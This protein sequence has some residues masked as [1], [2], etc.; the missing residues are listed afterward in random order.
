[1]KKDLIS[2]LLTKLRNAS[3]VFHKFVDIEYSKVNE[4]I[5][6]L[7]KKEGYIQNYETKSF[8]KIIVELRFNGWWTKSSF[9]SK[10]IRIS[11][12][13]R[14]IYSSYKDFNKK[15]KGLNFEQGII[16]L[17]TSSGLMTNIKAKELKKGGEILFYIS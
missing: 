14:K 13:G 11:K 1:M 4:E 8:R 15:V 10:I 7:L 3:K 5:L 12:P 9:F 6:K 2:N 17:S 16:I